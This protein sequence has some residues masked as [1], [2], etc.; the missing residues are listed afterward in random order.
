[1]ATATL[2]DTRLSLV[3]ETAFADFSASGTLTPFLGQRLTVYDSAGKKAI[4]YI[5]AA[6]SGETY[7]DIIGG[8][9]PTLGDGDFNSD[10]DWTVGTNWSIDT[11]AKT[12]SHAA[13]ASGYL[14]SKTGAV[15]AGALYY[16]AYTITSISG[17]ANHQLI[18]GSGGWPYV[19]TTGE[20]SAYRVAITTSA[21]N[22]FAAASQAMT[23]NSMTVRKVLTPSAT[24]VTIT[25]TPGGVG[26]QLGEHRER[27]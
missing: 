21:P 23:I 2:A 5:K 27:V 14:T 1:M 3:N 25:S 18:V 12:A 4:G 16:G 26:I 10:A 24:G 9:D 17:G 11:G 8:T 20:N 22:I 7:L 13:I 6:G 15:V 19:A